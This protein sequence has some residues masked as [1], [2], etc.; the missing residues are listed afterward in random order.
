MVEV[1]VGVVGDGTVMKHAL[2][3]D[4]PKTGL[5]SQFVYRHGKM[6]RIGWA[7]KLPNRCNAVRAYCSS[8]CGVVVG[9]WCSLRAICTGD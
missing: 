2:G 6:S 7:D 4:M 8:N 5:N 9:T 3:T 1:R